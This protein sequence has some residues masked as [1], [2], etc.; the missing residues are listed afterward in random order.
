MPESQTSGEVTK[1]ELERLQGT[2]RA[3]AV[4]VDGRPVLPH[5]FRDAKL[6]IS[7][8]RFRLHNPLPDAEQREEG[9]FTP[10]PS[11]TP[12]ALDVTPDGGRTL[13]EIY[14]L[15][16]DTLQV[17]YPVG[18][19]NRPAD[20]KTAPASGLSLVTYEREQA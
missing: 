8:S 19:G 4:E 2:W 11:K 15:R 1:Q 13:E 12:K 17:C 20:F 3:V 16:G 9:S 7:G 10:D 14:E 18:G 6:V 5:L